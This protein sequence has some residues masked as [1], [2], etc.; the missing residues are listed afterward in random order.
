M[1]ITL[2]I[3]LSHYLALSISKSKKSIFASGHE[4]SQVK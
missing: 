3:V 1:L 2:F 4:K